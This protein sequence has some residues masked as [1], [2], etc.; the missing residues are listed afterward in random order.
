MSYLDKLSEINCFIFDVDGVFTDASLYVFEHGELMRKMNAKDGFALQWA[1][2]QGYRVILI[3]GGRSQSVLERFK[4][5]GVEEI[6]WGISDKQA[7]L[8][9]LVREEDLELRACLYM[10]DD[11]PDYGCMRLVNLP[12]CPSDAVP[13][14]LQLAQYISPFGG[15]QG[16]V[17]DVIEKVL[18][19]QGKWNYLQA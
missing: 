2:K 11:L 17:R 1:V 7:V 16:C 12:T 8:E 19:V 14:I 9:R 10:G 15:G 3:T 18:R 13:E 5:L 6:F 4:A